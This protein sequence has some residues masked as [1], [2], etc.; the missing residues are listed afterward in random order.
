[1]RSDAIFGQLCEIAPSRNIRSPELVSLCDLRLRD[2]T[3]PLI[4][5][6]LR[7]ECYSASA[8]SDKSVDS[9]RYSKAAKPT[10]LG[11]VAAQT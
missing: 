1:M 7:A 10:S 3:N 5:P 8:G 11:E 6:A 9:M 4:S 2:K